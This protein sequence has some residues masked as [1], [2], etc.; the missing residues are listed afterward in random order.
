VIVNRTCNPNQS[1]AIYIH[2]MS[3]HIARHTN[4]FISVFVVYKEVVCLGNILKMVNLVL[5][6]WLEADM[7]DFR[8]DDVALGC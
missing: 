8:H 6:S 3:M 1:D 4:Q 2:E 7:H 5:G